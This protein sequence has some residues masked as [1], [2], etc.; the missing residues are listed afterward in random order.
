MEPIFE[1]VRTKDSFED[2]PWCSPGFYQVLDKEFPESKFI[3][4]IRDSNNWLRSFKQ[5][6]FSSNDNASGLTQFVNATFDLSSDESIKETY[7]KHNY[8]VQQYFQDRDNLLVVDWEKG[9]GWKEVCG[10]LNQ[11][12]VDMPFPHINRAPN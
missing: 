7:E 2:L 12:I 3:L 9:D 4:T 8:D 6:W 10:F 11:P 1:L 5:E